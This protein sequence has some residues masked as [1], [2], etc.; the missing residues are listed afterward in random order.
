M[1]VA[2]SSHMIIMGPDNILKNNANNSIVNK[3]NNS[4]SKLFVKKIN[5]Q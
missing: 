4:W 3:Q 1:V 2:F 5:T